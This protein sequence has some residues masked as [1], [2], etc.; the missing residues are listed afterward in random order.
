M[1]T[2]LITAV[3]VALLVILD[4]AVKLWATAVLAPVGAMPLI[5]GVVEL[6][7]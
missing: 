1:T 6:R 5:P 3:V 2:V 7:Y 4:Q